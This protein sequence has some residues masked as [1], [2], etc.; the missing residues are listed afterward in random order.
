MH[1]LRVMAFAGVCFVFSAPAIADEFGPR[2]WAQAPA[3]LGDYTA[4]EVPVQNIAMED[5][6]KNLQDIAPA[7]GDE[8]DQDD[9]IIVSEKK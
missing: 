5:A 2:F 6:A 7:A 3:G 9:K 4:P 8:K 1:L